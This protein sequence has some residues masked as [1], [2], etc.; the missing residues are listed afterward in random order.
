VSRPVVDLMSREDE[1]PMEWEWSP[2]SSIDLGSPEKAKETLVAMGVV[3]KD[4]GAEKEGEKEDAGKEVHVKKEG[5][6]HKRTV[7]EGVVRLILEQRT[8]SDSPSP[9][10]AGIEQQLKQVG[11]HKDSPNERYVAKGPAGPKR[12]H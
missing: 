1:P 9:M 11:L 7:S 4:G 2:Q 10:L 12:F 8:T 6:A 3:A 5:E